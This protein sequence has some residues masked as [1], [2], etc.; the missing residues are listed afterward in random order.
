MQEG[1]LEAKSLMAGLNELVQ[2]N[3]T[4]QQSDMLRTDSIGTPRARQQALASAV[5]AVKDAFSDFLKGIVLDMHAAFMN[6]LARIL[7]I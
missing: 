2:H 7:H 5:D 3:A 1:V 4:K 6:A